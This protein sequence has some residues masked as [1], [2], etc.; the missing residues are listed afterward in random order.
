MEHGGETIGLCPHGKLPGICEECLKTGEGQE[1]SQEVSEEAE[2]I[3]SAIAQKLEQETGI[4]PYDVV[5]VLGAGFR[6]PSIHQEKPVSENQSGY[7]LNAESRLRLNAA[8]QLYLEG[9]TRIICTTGGKALSE[10]WKEYPSLAE[11]GKTYL[12]EKF[13][14][15]EKD[16]V[17]ETKSDATHGN[18]AYGLREIYKDNIPVGKF[19]ML[20][21]S[22]HLRRA[23]EMAK[24]S[25]IR[26]ELIPAEAELLKQSPH[27]KKYI[28]NWMK[29]DVQKALE[30]NETAK[31]NDESYWEDRAAV[32]ETPLDQSVPAVDVSKSVS[33]TAK[34]LAESGVDGVQTD[35]F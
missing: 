3:G 27:Y 24:R 29:E 17:M 11:L 10:K 13:K 25:G 20:S 22:Y 30:D 5:M 19:A 18:L 32:F 26:A 9:R 1:R 15:P 28:D 33:E 12:I 2:K 16:I 14:I 6:E 7:L 8:A 31:L 23:E 21:S 35:A 34:R 4:K